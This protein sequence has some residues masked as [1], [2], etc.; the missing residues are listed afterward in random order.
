MKQIIERPGIDDRSVWVGC[1]A[2][3][4]NGDL[5]GRWLWPEEGPDW[6]CPNSAR[7]EADGFG[8][9]EETWVM[10]HQCFGG[11]LQGECSPSEALRI[12]GLLEQIEDD[13]EDPDLV[14][15]WAD[16]A[17]VDVDDWTA[18]SYAYDESK[19]GVYQSWVDFAEQNVAELG[20]NGVMPDVIEQLGSAIDYDYIA[21][22]LRH[23]YW[24]L[25]FDGALHVFRSN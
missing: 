22:E 8:P 15:A 11:W 24:G 14:R 19:A 16:Q 9:H 23:D 1:L 21:R 25:D 2:C 5:V 18:A 13:G 7:E 6:V 12:A 20:W 10:D 3:Y 4:N 17:G